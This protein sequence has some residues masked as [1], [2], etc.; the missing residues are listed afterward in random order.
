MWV[1]VAGF[2]FCG[3]P[4]GY[5]LAFPTHFGLSGLWL[6]SLTGALIV[7][8]SASTSDP[9]EVHLIVCSI[10]ALDVPSFLIHALRGVAC[11]PS[12]AFS[13]LLCL[14]V[15]AR[16]LAQTL[17]HF[18]HQLRNAHMHMLMFHVHFTWWSLCLKLHAG[19]HCWICSDNLA[20]K[21]SWNR[22]MDGLVC[23]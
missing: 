22:C 16:V 1:G 10:S 15:F 23:F 17:V 20:C 12:H 18:G 3:V 13:A 6:G 21:S 5:T 7:C 8:K 19:K 9:S 14:G 11:L 4:L 2:W